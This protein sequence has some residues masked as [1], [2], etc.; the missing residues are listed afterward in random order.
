MNVLLCFTM[1]F[2]LFYLFCGITT[3]MPPHVLD[4]QLRLVGSGAGFELKSLASGPRFFNTRLY[5]GLI[6]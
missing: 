3:L 2:I 5:T 4:G 6:K 1:Y